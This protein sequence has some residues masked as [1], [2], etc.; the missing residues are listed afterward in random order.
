[1]LMLHQTLVCGKGAPHEYKVD[2]KLTEAFSNVS[3]LYIF[4]F[5]HMAAVL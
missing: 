1:M 4:N 2:N 5:I 3:Q